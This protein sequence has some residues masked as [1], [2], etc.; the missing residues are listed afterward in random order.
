MKTWLKG[1]LIALGILIIYTVFITLINWLFGGITSFSIYS[2]KIVLFLFY[3]L[4]TYQGLSEETGFII[5]LLKI[6]ILTPLSWFIIG[7]IIGFIISKIRNRK[8]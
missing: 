8:K 3:L 2:E 5:G 1:G 4:P 6:Y 7:A